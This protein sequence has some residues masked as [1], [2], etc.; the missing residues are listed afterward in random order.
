M[1]PDPRNRDAQ[2]ISGHGHR[3]FRAT[4]VV[5]R[6]RPC[7][8]SAAWR[9]ARATLRRRGE[10]ENRGVVD[11][12]AAF[13]QRKREQSGAERQIYVGRLIRSPAPGDRRRRGGRAIEITANGEILTESVDLGGRHDGTRRFASRAKGPAGASGASGSRRGARD[14]QVQKCHVPGAP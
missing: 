14:M 5:D 11:P 10:I 2:S 8:E 12:G 1:H 13:A 3:R 9:D 4:D 7:S 6:G